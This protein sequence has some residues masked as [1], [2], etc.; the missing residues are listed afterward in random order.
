VS[1]SPAVSFSGWL[2]SMF[3]FDL[4]MYLLIYCM[5]SRDQTHV[6]LRYLPSLTSKFLT[7]ISLLP[8]HIYTKTS[9]YQTQHPRLLILLVPE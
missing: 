1:T 7:D 4:F 6:Q 2:V 3:G 8:T 9:T 5:S